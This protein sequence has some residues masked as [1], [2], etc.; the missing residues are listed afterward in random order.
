MIKSTLARI[1]IQHDHFFNENSLY[2]SGAVWEVL[3][4]LTTAGYIYESAVRENESDEVKEQNKNLEPAKWFRSTQFG[5]KEDRVVLKS[6]GSPTYTLPDIA[7]HLNKL[8]RDFDLLVNVLGADHIVEAQVVRNGVQALGGDV[9]KINVI[10][11]QFVRLIRDGKEYKMSTRGGNYETLDDLIDQT[12]ADAVRYV[13]LARNTNSRL[14]FDLDLAVKQTNE[15]PVYY[16]QYAYV[17][18]AGIF[19]EAVARGFSD[20]GEVDYSLLGDEELAFIRKILTLGEEIERGVT[21]F[22]P[23]VIAFY[24]LDLANA[25]H[26]MYDRVRVFGEGVDP[27]VAK[28]R[29]RFY[30]AALTAFKRVLLLMGMSTPER[31]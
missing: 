10:I 5:D 26:P 23:H 19:R 28:V 30:R 9:S 12:S 18:C 8:N 2:D 17:R 25:F 20:E 31:M 4:D 13:L 3:T 7:Y 24:A 1:D 16:I 11:M 27:E 15:N 22:T 29:L 21:N 6:D 14:D